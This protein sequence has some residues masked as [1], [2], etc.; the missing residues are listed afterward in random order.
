[1]F[2]SHPELV[3]QQAAN[4]ADDSPVSKAAMLIV[5]DVTVETAWFK[6]I[7]KS[8]LGDP[9][10]ATLK[11]NGPV[12]CICYSPDGR[13]IA[14]GSGD[15]FGGRVIIWDAR[16]GAELQ[17]YSM[18]GALKSMQFSGDGK[19]LMNVSDEG[20]VVL[21]DMISWKERARQVEKPRCVPENMPSHSGFGCFRGSLFCSWMSNC[22]LL[23]PQSEAF[24]PR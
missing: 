1:V 15:G 14:S 17:S 19:L 10:Q 11:C 9:C 5:S 13:K 20:T 12:E 18:P 16:S 24:Y 7:N 8:Q 21:I 6:Y 22:I 23:S 4:M 2:R 3:I